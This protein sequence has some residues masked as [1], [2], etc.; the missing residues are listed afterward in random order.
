MPSARK[1]HAVRDRSLGSPC[2]A[3]IETRHLLPFSGFGRHGL[4]A[5]EL[6]HDI[7]DLLSVS[8]DTRRRP[9]RQWAA[10]RASSGMSA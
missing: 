10:A 7:E 9:M 8:A 5:I 1:V 4:A 2:R 3:Q 6:V